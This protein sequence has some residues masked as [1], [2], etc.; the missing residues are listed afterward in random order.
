MLIMLTHLSMQVLN[1][2]TYPHLMGL[3]DAL[4][5]ETEESE[6]SFALSMDSGALE[7]GSHSLGTIFA[8]R[9]NLWKL[10]F[11]RMIWDVIKFG[12][13]APQVYMTNL[14]LYSVRILLYFP[15]S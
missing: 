1:L 8:Q 5:I 6:M 14:S 13:Q 7:W 11:W 2:T 12:Q 15:C 3:L 9:A 4:G 10:S